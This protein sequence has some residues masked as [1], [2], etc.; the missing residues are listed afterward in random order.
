MERACKLSLIIC[1]YRRPQAVGSLLQSL[2]AQTRLPDE[3]LIVDASPDQQTECVVATYIQQNKIPRLQYFNVPP[4]HRGL[5]RQRNYGIARVAGEIVA[6]LD[7][8]TIPEP[9]YFEELLASFARNPQAGGISGYITNGINWEKSANTAKPSLALFQW[10]GWV[11]REGYRNRLRKLLGLDSPLPP[12]WMPPCGHGRPGAYPPDGQDYPVE[13]LMGCAFAFPKEVFSR[14]H[15]SRFFEGYGLY[16]DA[17]FCLRVAQQSPLFLCIRARVAHYHAAEG[18][19]NQ[20]RY[21]LMVVRNG[22][23]VWRRR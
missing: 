19:P 23:F 18:R 2:E 14:F 1:T 12:G 11:R 3:T 17:D 7:D 15:F 4:E 21:G 10:D 22:W 6:F 9:S 8:D 5:T 13:F 20:F 16:E